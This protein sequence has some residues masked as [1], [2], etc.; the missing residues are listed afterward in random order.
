VDALPYADATTH[1]MTRSPL[2]LVVLASGRGSNLAAILA[3]CAAGELA[4]EVVAVFSD[5]AKAGA[6]TIAHHANIPTRILKPG[7]FASRLEY[8]RKLFDEVD[9]YGPDL[10]VCAGFMRVLSAEMVAPRTQKLIN[11]HPSLLPKYAGLHTHQRALESGDTEH[12]ASVHFVIPA[13]DAGPVIAQTRIPVLPA[14]TSETLA[15]RLLPAE[16]RLL[17]ATIALYAARRVEHERGQVSIDGVAQKVP[18][19]F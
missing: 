13:L 4:A 8:D 14:D 16:H 18:Q 2:R 6:L 3:A 5:K 11:I 17:V 9:L 15:A 7:G 10:I 19:T 1:S 12:G